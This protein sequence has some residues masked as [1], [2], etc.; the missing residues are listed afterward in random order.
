MLIRR[1]VS[2]RGQHSFDAKK[3][4]IF[5]PVSVIITTPA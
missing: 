3:T 5:R 1:A 4:D 2:R